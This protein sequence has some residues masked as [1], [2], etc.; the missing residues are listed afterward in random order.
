MQ[1]ANWD[2]WQHLVWKS[3]HIPVVQHKAVAEGSTS[4]TNRRGWLLWIT[5]GAK[6]L[7]DRQMLQVSSIPVCFLPFLWLLYLFTYQLHLSLS[8]SISLSLSIY[9]PTYPSIRPSVHP[10]VNQSINQS[11]HPS[12]HPSINQ[13]IILSFYHSLIL[14][15]QKWSTVLLAFW[16]HNVQTSKKWSEVVRTWCVSYILNHFDLNRASRHK[17]V[18]FSI[19][20]LATSRPTNHEKN[21][22]FRN[23]PNISRTCIFFLLAFSLS[24]FYC[25]LLFSA[26]HVSMLSEVW[27]LNFLRSINPITIN[28][29]AIID[30]HWCI[31][32]PI[33]F[34]QGVKYVELEHNSQQQVQLNVKFVL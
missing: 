11:I 7:M 33:W 21:A 1:A 26:F 27:L 9:L 18:H 19:S 22:M 5:G 29:K 15:F 12:I 23:F 10:S 8:F 30:D 20:H 17:A 31:S 25:F 4:Q 14:N 24:L 3:V 32:A 34:W 16:V 6:T 13:S 2:E 28:L